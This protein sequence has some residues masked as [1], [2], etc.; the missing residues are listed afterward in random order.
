[1]PID[2]GLIGGIHVARVT[3]AEAAADLDQHDHEAF[4]AST[5][6]AL[7][8]GSLAGDLTIG[9]LL[10]HGDLGLGTRNLLDGELIVVDGEAWVARADGSV[11]RAAP[12]D[13]TPFAVVCRFTAEIEGVVGPGGFDAV[14]AQVDALAPPSAA[15]LA[16][17][18]DA[19]VERASLRSVP[20][21]DQPA[22][23]LADAIAAQVVWEAHGFDA[24]IVGFRFPRDVDGLELP[25]WH[26]HL[27]ADDRSVA[28][29]VLDLEI[30]RGRAQVEIQDE[31]HVEV[32]AGVA[33]G[34]VGYDPERVRRLEDMERD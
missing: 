15:C 9:E 7:L 20:R 32:P 6:D 24:A 21:Q 16:V 4:Q 26:L 22:P 27:I 17:R 33:V 30:A 3:R 19:R 13:R 31:L 8:R 2:D 23:T 11:V 34:R 25:G 29:H 14:T 10:D 5:L 28:G 18:I 12:D 1:V